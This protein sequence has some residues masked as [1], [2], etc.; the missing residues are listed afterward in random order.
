M[1]GCYIDG[2]K[3]YVSVL[4]LKSG[5]KIIPLKGHYLP[6]IGDYIIG[7]ISEERF[8]G[9]EVDINAPFPSSISA[10][11]IRETFQV[12]DV[13]SAKVRMVDEVHTAQLVEPRKLYAGRLIEIESVKVPRVIGRNGSMLALIK[14][15]TGSDIFVGKNG[16]IYVKNGDIALSV[17]AL[18]K[19]SSEAHTSGLTDRIKELLE[20]ES[21]NSP[22]NHG[23]QKP[24]VQQGPQQ[25]QPA[26]TY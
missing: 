12:G 4:S 7:I 3:T 16:R 21:K 10:R 22:V 24:P 5:D 18:L 26:E 17:M 6:R 9:Y 13:V 20:T 19:I 23:P 8:S 2:G 25:E 11:D 15:Y 1:D 14:E